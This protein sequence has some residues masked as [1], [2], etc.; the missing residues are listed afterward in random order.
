M[1][2]YYCPEK[3]IG[4]TIIET[5]IQMIIIRSSL[6]RCSPNLLQLAPQEFSSKMLTG[7]L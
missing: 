2:K 6:N 3:L 4:V 5:V 7:Y 1:R